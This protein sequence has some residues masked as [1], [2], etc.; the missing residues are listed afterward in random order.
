MQL[1][2]TIPAD[3][4]PVIAAIRRREKQ[5]RDLGVTALYVYGSRA[6]G[7]HQGDSD[8]DIMVEYDPQVFSLFDMVGV[9]HII[10]DETG[11]VTHVSTRS[12]FRP[13]NAHRYVND[14]VEVL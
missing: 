4:A 5:I 8:L 14:L 3:L 6:R 1:A 7:D 13:V 2:K 11:L 9:Q 12:S 10:G